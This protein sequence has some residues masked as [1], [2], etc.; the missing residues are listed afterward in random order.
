MRLMNTCIAMVLFFALLILGTVYGT[1]FVDS[2]YFV[3]KNTEPVTFTIPQ[4]SS[5]STIGGI[6]ENKGIIEKD[7]FFELYTTLLTKNNNMKP[8]IFT[9]QPNST[10][11]DIVNEI[12]KAP[13]L[14][15]KTIN[16]TIPEGYT[17][18]QIAERLEENNVCS[19]SDFIELAKSKPTLDYWFLQNVDNYEGFLFPDT[20]DF[21]YFSTAK[22]VLSKLVGEFDNKLKKLGIDEN[23][24][25]IY[26]IV[27][28]ASL[29][30]K[31]AYHKEDMPKISSVIENRIKKDMLL[32]IDA[33]IL[34][35]IG[36]KDKIYQ[37]DLELDDPYNLY[38]YKGLPPTPICNPGTDAISA[39]LK[40]EKT[41][42]IFYVADSETKYHHFSKTYEE[43]QRNIEKY[44]N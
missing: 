25:N 42:Y 31:E 38:K 14:E 30:E 3:S 40:P 1:I 6:L 24:E 16:L 10:M 17:I 27:K 18:E 15:E 29:I 5:I 36:H 20:Y 4:G 41:N 2:K 37:S 22:Q 7:L 13:E 33:S 43:H 26:D 21:Y 8:G 39:V 32:Q 35:S 19:K 23:T 12:E 34:Y 11:T 9:V 28:K 44:M